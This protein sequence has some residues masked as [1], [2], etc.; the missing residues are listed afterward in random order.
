MFTGVSARSRLRSPL[1]LSLGRRPSAPGY[2]WPLLPI[3]RRKA[4]IAAVPAKD[5]QSRQTAGFLMKVGKGNL[6]V[7]RGHVAESRDEEE[8][9]DVPSSALGSAGS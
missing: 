6:P 3:A 5:V 4:S 7:V 2:D 8:S 9:T 1:L